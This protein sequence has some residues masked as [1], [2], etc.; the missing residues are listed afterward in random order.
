MNDC[1][2]EYRLVLRLEIY[3]GVIHLGVLRHQ[4]MGRNRNET[5]SIEL[6]SYRIECSG[7][8]VSLT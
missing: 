5:L 1:G 3:R 8:V 4:R 2:A 7:I 6:N